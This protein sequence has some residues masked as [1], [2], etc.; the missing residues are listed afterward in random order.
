MPTASFPLAP[1]AVIGILGGGQLGRM[2]A[3]AAARLGFDAAI[4]TPRPDAP[5]GRVAAHTIRSAYDDAQGLAELARLSAVVTYEFE[6]VPAAAV[7]RLAALGCPVAPGARALAVAQDRIVEKRFFEQIGVPTVAFAAIDSAADIAPA[8]ARLGCPALLKTRREGYDGKGQAWVRSA[9]EAEAA[10]ARIG[11]RPAILEAR[12]PF[13]RELSV[14]AARG[15]DGATAAYPAAENHHEAGVLR[16]SIA[17]AELRPATAEAARAIALTLLEALDYV[18]VIGVELFELDGGQLMVNEFAP[19]VHNSGHWTLDGC[20]VDQFEQHIRAV[21]GWPLGPADPLAAVE[22]T[23]LLGEEA[24]GWAR[25]A[26]DP[27]ARIWL[28]GKHETAPGRK[29]GHV[30]RLRPLKGPLG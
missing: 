10:F 25:L 23:N 1:G 8:L 15:R 19:R 27:S 4:L 12:A 11:G 6:N 2:L 7:D 5:A 28:Y 20:E 9:D 21:A 24:D 30:N 29:M 26:A 3:L 13:V 22:M 17:P 14:I 16:R 18:G